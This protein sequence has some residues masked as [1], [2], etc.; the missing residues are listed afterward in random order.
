[1]HVTA[2]HRA[3]RDYV[4]SGLAWA[5]SD[6]VEPGVMITDNGGACRIWLS[7]PTSTEDWGMQAGHQQGLAIVFDG[8]PTPF[9]LNCVAT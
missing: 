5:T 2:V 1:M 7:G 3:L 8:E 4:G 9:V 6:G